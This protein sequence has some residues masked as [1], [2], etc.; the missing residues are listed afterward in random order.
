[1]ADEPVHGVDHLVGDD[2]VRACH[3]TTVLSIPVC[4]TAS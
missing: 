3:Q 1:L 2:H 4:P